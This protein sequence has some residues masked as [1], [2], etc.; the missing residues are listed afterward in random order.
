MQHART[1]PCWS[2]YIEANGAW[3]DTFD[4]TRRSYEDRPAQGAD[5]L[6]GGEAHPQGRL[7]QTAGMGRW[8]GA[9]IRTADEDEDTP[10]EDEAPPEP[11]VGLAQASRPRSRLAGPNH[12][13]FAPVLVGLAS[14]AWVAAFGFDV[15]SRVSDTEWV[16]ARGAWLL[17]ALGLIAGLVGAFAV[18]HD[19]VGIPRGTRAFAVGVRR[20]IALDVALAL[21]TIS[22]LVRNASDF[23][24]HDPSPVAA[25]AASVLGLAALGCALWLEGILTFAYGVRVATDEERLAGFEPTDD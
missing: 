20:L 25:V 12:H 16:Y 18:L 10:M 13:P 24:F 4:V 11:A 5:A 1:K 7:W 3:H 14:G 22:F 23:A 2:R 6:P 21:F 9:G 8:A 15:Y 17:T 19:L